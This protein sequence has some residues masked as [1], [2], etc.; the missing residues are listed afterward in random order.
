VETN[1][2]QGAITLTQAGVV[3]AGSGAPV[4]TPWSMVF[5]AVMLEKRAYVLCERRAPLPPWICVTGN[6]DQDL[7]ALQSLVESVRARVQ[8]R[9]YRQ[10][11]QQPMPRQELE[12][13][14][15]RGEY[16]PGALEVPIG[17]GPGRLSRVAQRVTMAGAG[18]TIV[19]LAGGVAVGAI[20]ALGA[21]GIGVAMPHIRRRGSKRGRR[22]LVL[23][24][25]GC[26]VGLPTGPRVFGYDEI[27][28][29]ELVQR[30]SLAIHVRDGRRAS[31]KI[32]RATG[33]T[34][35][36]LDG[37]WFGAPLPLIVAVAEAYR[38]RHLV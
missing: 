22:V 9:G 33:G 1:K 25:H 31:L 20:A 23:T 30:N 13:K 17:P 37:R 3:H 18:A 24:P 27:G 11:K 15:L 10:A 14:V 6:S 21:L 12:A 16:I 19:G 8:E 4:E 26:V 36:V 38:I 32:T 7:A 34:I 5:G 28:A 35:G 2:I 29:F